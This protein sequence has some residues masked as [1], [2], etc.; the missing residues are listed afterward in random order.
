[1]F[2]DWQYH[3]IVSMCLLILCDTAVVRQ[4]CGLIVKM[5]A[6]WHESTRIVNI[7]IFYFIKR[8]YKVHVELKTDNFIMASNSITSLQIR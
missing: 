2:L 1:M 6:N 4:L 5:Y 3:R 8:T 7:M